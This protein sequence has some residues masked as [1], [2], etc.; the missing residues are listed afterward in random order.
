MSIS[1]SNSVEGN[2]DYT[3]CSDGYNCGYCGA[4]VFYGQEHH[5]GINSPSVSFTYP[6]C[7]CFSQLQQLLDKLD[8]LITLMME[9]EE[10]GKR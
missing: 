2:S 1:I 5:C 9:R 10:R 8:K 7:S 4:W 6:C 3:F